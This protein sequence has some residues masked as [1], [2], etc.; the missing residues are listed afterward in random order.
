MSSIRTNRDLYCFLQDVIANH[1]A[2]PP[3]L[4]VY[5]RSLLGR[6]QPLGDRPSL[7]ADTFA[8]VL[9]E[10]FGAPASGTP[11]STPAVESSGFAKV[12]AILRAQ[13]E[14][15]AAMDRTGQLRDEMRYFGSDAP[16]G[17]RW[18]NFD[19]LTYLECGAQG[20]FGGWDEEDDNGRDLV[21]GQVAVLDDSG[22]L[23]RMDPGDLDDPV[24][25]LGDLG[26]DS[27]E[28]FLWCGQYYE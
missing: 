20:A 11:A 2:D 3:S 6:L 27:V 19:P 25:E 7:D 15:L 14:D 17:A 26:W 28:R 13:I 5:L 24:T 4:E 22:E 16:S 18:Y 8:R 21:P 23:Q 9:A 1:R 10:A 12:A